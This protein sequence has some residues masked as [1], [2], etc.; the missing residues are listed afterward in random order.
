M[1][2]AVTTDL[3]GLSDGLHTV[4]VKAFDL[5]GNTATTSVTFRVDTIKPGHNDHFSA[6]RVS[7][8]SSSVQVT[9]SEPIP[10][11]ASRDTN[12]ASTDWNGARSLVLSPTRSPDLAKGDHTVDVRA[13]DRAGNHLETSVTFN[14]DTVA[15]TIR[16]TGPMEGL[17]TNST[18]VSVFWT[19]SDATS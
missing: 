8:A 6:R 1:D 12:T 11:P 10:A 7:L 4:Y 15:P 14:V 3:T 19:G 13:V 2:G 17:N 16:I 9:W 5:V 18:T